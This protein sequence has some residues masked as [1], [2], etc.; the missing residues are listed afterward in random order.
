M[1]LENPVTRAKMHVSSCSHVAVLI[2]G[3]RHGFWNAEAKEAAEAAKWNVGLGICHFLGESATELVRSCCGGL[4]RRKGGAGE[5]SSGSRSQARTGKGLG[6]G[7]KVN[8][9][10]VFVLTQE[11]L[12]Q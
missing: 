7:K 9:G 8:R 1:R 5:R 6:G 3:D 2:R 11:K 4:G 10:S 12:P